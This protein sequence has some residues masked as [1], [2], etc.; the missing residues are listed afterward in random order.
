[1]RI[2]GIDIGSTSVKGV[3]L[4]SSLGR[5]VIQDYH[6]RPLDP[7][8]PNPTQALADLILTLPKQPDKV[9][10]LLRT[11]ATTFRNLTLPTKDRKALQAGV[12]FE[13]EDELPFP[14]DQSLFDYSVLTTSKAGSQ[15]HV[16]A[17]L[18]SSAQQLLELWKTAG[19]DPDVLTSEA[20]ALR[21][22]W[23]RV[24]ASQ[25]F[26]EDPE[27]RARPF[28]HCH[29]GHDHS[30]LYIQNQG[31]PVLAREIRW[32]GRDITAAICKK[33]SLPIDQAEAA[34]LDHG[35]VVTQGQRPEVTAEQAEFSDSLMEVLSL[36]AAEIRQATLA[37][38]GVTRA[39]FGKVYLSGG[40]SLL[41]GLAPVLEELL[42]VPVQSVHALGA[43]SG[44]TYSE[45]TEA[46]FVL[47]AAS[48]FAALPSEK[49]TPINLRKGP[50][51][52]AGKAGKLN[53][54]SLKKPMIAVGTVAFSA[55]LSLAIQSRVYQSRL[56]EV[57]SQLEKSIKAFFGQISGSALRGYVGNPKNLKTSVQKE[58]SKQ[59]ALN[60][61]YA[62]NPRSPL[63]FLRELSVAVPKDVVV[64]LIEYQ[65]GAAPASSYLANDPHSVSLTFIVA[66][67]QMAERLS[68]VL[69][70]KIA[71]LAQG[72]MEE[73]PAPD[74]PGKR[75]KVTFT[76]KPQEGSYG[77]L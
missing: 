6:E 45:P 17:T 48:A 58:I 25:H 11:S 13:L 41:P 21:S 28:L 22:L 10:A 19:V 27:S 73:A 4:E 38:K 37:A 7:A 40:T 5:F 30:I 24:L 49:A 62:A 42:Q 66:N 54:S 32:G 55:F 8:N 26:T 74:G 50:L 68:K 18:Q 12:G 69:G 34:K 59:R 75:W 46:G 3:E 64:D 67:P 43:L 2:L 77:N 15:V 51:A 71:D 33:Y 35:F 9:V 39:D 31:L 29:L 23:T 76:G 53:W 44:S 57:D 61:L 1:M 60:R 47:A 63:D 36:L 52:K 14:S 72:K 70:S 16:T 56:Q 65:V 20:W